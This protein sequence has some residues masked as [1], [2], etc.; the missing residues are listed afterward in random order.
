[1]HMD[2]VGTSVA[3]G[4]SSRSTTTV[5]S[6]LSANRIST[7]GMVNDESCLQRTHMNT[8]IS[9]IATTSITSIIDGGSSGGGITI[10]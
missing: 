5:T 6:Q 8:D 3:D 4:S 1:M 10:T 7:T 9:A 2:I